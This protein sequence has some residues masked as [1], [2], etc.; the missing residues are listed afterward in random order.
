MTF[1]HGHN[2]G[3]YSTPALGAAACNPEQLTAFHGKL[4][5]RAGDKLHG[6]EL[7][8]SNGTRAGT[9]IVKEIQPG[10]YGSFWAT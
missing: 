5:F 4:Y 9:K 10:E 6:P 1:R 2:P 7:W 8:K 3:C